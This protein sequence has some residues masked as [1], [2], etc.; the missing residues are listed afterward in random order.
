MPKVQLSV[1]QYIIYYTKATFVALWN[2]SIQKVVPF[3]SRF[4]LNFY[5][6]C[7][8]IFLELFTPNKRLELFLEVIT[9]V[10]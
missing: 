2:R 10:L 5:E 7:Y 8:I 1:S 6:V 9:R 4:E 3:L